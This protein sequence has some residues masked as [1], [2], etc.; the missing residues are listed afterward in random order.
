M[1]PK[2]L[3]QRT[4]RISLPLLAILGGLLLSACGGGDAEPVQAA[5]L[6]QP[7][8]EP[9][10]TPSIVDVPPS[11]TP[12]PTVVAEIPPLVSRT[13]A[14]GAVL[15]AISSCA[16]GVASVSSTTTSGVRLFFDS[17][18][19]SLGRAWQIEAN[20]ADFA[21]TFG[22]W[23]VNEGALLQAIAVDRVAERIANSGLDCAF[24]AVLLEADPA[25]PR[26]VAP[27]VILD[28]SAELLTGTGSESDGPVALITSA[29]LASIRV[30]S[31]C[32][33]APRISRRSPVSLRD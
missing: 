23:R 14:E 8:V 30:W 15:E 13:D 17:T 4:R 29:D 11:P 24:P 21:V 20:T 7:A 9:T 5:A 18:F 6:T 32:T 2:Q 31:G 12:T 27:E 1:T 22:Q 10:P 25:P 28:P 3:A 16:E 26:F 19:L 33:A